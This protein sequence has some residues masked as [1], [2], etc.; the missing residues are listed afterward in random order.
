ML[1]VLFLTFDLY[2]VAVSRR[3]CGQVVSVLREGDGCHRARVSREVCHVGALLQIPNLDL[4]VG[5][6]STE[7]QTV[8]VEL[9]ARQSW[10]QRN[11]FRVTQELWY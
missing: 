10:L 2:N 4:G 11:V 8:R 6:A 7:D 1:C 9:G 3:T 5:R